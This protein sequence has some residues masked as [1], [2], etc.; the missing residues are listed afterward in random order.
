M[1]HTPEETKH[2][3]EV[4][5][6]DC[7]DGWRNK[8]T[9]VMNPNVCNILVASDRH[10]LR[11]SDKKRFKYQDYEDAHPDWYIPPNKLIKSTLYWKWFICKYE[12]KLFE[13]YKAS[14]MKYPNA[15]KNIDK[16]DIEKDLCSAYRLN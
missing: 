5:Q 10:F 7:I 6:I 3:A 8:Q 13:Y 16:A 15:W 4:H 9:Q 2:Y 14:S 1:N 11:Q 12:T